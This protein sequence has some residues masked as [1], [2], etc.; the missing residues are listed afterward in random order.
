M[1]IT[2]IRMNS[3]NFTKKYKLSTYFLIL[4]RNYFQ[5]RNEYNPFLKNKKYKYKYFNIHYLSRK[6]INKL[7]LNE[8]IL[9][10]PKYIRNAIYILWLKRYYKEKLLNTSLKPLWYDHYSLVQKQLT[11]TKLYNVHFLHLD[12]NTL[13][14]N[15]RYILRFQCNFCK[16]YFKNNMDTIFYNLINYNIEY[17][18]NDIPYTE[19]KWNSYIIPKINANNDILYFTYIFNPLYDISKPIISNIILNI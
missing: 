2:V 13:P 15:K 1:I 8:C 12:F 10:L 16:E 9:Q 11:K 14:E 18:L 5:S 4:K 17:F 19:S 6:E 3:K 7:Q